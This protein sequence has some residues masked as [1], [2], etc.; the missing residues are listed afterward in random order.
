MDGLEGQSS[1]T[2]VGFGLLGGEVSHGP[3]GADFVG[4]SGEAGLE[5]VGGA[6]FAFPDGDDVPSEGFEMGRSDLIAM[7]VAG[8]LRF[9]IGGVG[10][11][12]GRIP[13]AFMPMPEA[14]VH[15]DGDAVLREDYIGAAREFSVL[16][17][18]SEAMSM[19]PLPNQNLRF[20]V[21]AADAGHAAGA[22]CG[23]QLVCH[24]GPM[25]LLFLE[26]GHDPLEEG[27]CGSG[28]I[29]S[30]GRCTAGRVV[31]YAGGVVLLTVDDDR[32]DGPGGA[33]VLLWFIVH[34]RENV[35]H[36]HLSVDLRRCIRLSEFLDDDG[37]VLLEKFIDPRINKDHLAPIAFKFID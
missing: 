12:S 37:V 9:P 11:R 18:E 31:C 1:G 24:D 22:L 20:G 5:G 35:G 19:E 8:D 10:L 30:I 36:E 15:H 2:A 16:E 21:L 34:E 27:R 17:A 33:A 6:E 7:A 28:F 29:G 14:A 26:K 4:E 25:D 23:G 13:A 32:Y 3:G